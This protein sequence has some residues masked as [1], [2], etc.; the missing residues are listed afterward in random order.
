MAKFAQGF[1][2]VKNPEKYIGKTKP[3]FRSSWEQAFMRT[4]DENPAILQ[5]ASEPLRIPYTNPLTN[6][7]TTYVP[8]FLLEYV[9][10]SG[11]KHRELVEVKPM[12]QS[13]FRNTGKKNAQ[14][15]QV[16]ALNAAKW[17]AAMNY[18]KSKGLKF[19]VV[20][21]DEIYRTNPPRNKK[22]RRTKYKR[23]KR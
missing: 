4:C 7:S 1:Y 18:A 10:K 15:Q 9:D 5:W 19:R 23:I 11:N 6:K 8:D 3:Y 13:G 17:F 21:E 16:E 14:Q 12:D 22:P 20:N 2:E